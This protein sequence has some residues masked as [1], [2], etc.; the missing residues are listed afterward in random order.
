MNERERPEMPDGYEYFE[1]EGEIEFSEAEVAW[2]DADEEEYKWVTKMDREILE[3][4]LV[5]KLTLTPAIIADN[6]SRSRSGVSRRLNSLQAGDLVEK[7]GRGKYSISKL[8]AGYVIMG[9]APDHE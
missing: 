2:L 5:S 4:L 6:I 3:V 8:G 9:P 1:P 7:E